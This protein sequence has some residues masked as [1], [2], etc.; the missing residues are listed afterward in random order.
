MHSKT[1]LA[2]RQFTVS[3]TQAAATEMISI[4]DDDDAVREMLV[5]LTNMISWIRRPRIPVC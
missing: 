2:E 1:K 3:P 4:I 5:S